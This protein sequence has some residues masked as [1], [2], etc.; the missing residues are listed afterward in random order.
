MPDDDPI[1]DADFLFRE[2]SKPDPSRPPSPKPETG[3]FDEYEVGGVDPE[4]VAVDPPPVDPP[5]ARPKP[6]P[7]RAET[8]RRPSRVA[9]DEPAVEVV[10]TRGAEWGPT[11]VRVGAAVLAVAVVLWLTLSFGNA[12]ITM[13]IMAAGGLLVLALAYPIAITLER[14]VRITPQQAVE[15][16]Y[17]ALSHHFPHFRRMWL[18]LGR[19]G[20]TSGAYGSF[21]GFQAYWAGRIER[22][23]ATGKASKST[24]LLFEV[25]E[26]D[27]DKSAGSTRVDAQYIVRVFVRGR[28][29]EGPIEVA[30]IRTEL[31]KG[32]DRMWYLTD[33]TLPGERL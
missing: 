10:W 23:K 16:Y 28:K 13:M 31:V 17:Q 15:D 30:N 27:S 3:D 6:E 32:P 12:L 9:D 22:L 11:I 18:L 33:G 29:A 26:F 4:P 24:P 8:R 19:A 25:A 14:P 1:A 5:R 7:D 2:A 20:K 21:E